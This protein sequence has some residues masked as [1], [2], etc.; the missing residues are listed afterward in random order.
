LNSGA[1]KEIGAGNERRRS[2]QCT[3]WFG[4]RNRSKG[5]MKIDRSKYE[6]NR[7]VF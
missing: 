7:A 4:N 2:L 3:Q 1:A 5:T 6:H